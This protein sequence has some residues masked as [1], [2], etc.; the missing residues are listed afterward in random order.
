MPSD[1]GPAPAG[2][3]AEAGFRANNFDAIRLGLALL[4]IYSHAHALSRVGPRVDPIGRLTGGAIDGGILAVDG[5]FA[6]S[7]FLIA[8]SWSTSADAGRYLL[9]RVTR[10][11]P[12]FA[13]AMAVTAGV[14]APLGSDP[15][16]Y[17]FRPGTLAVTAGHTV[18]LTIYP[19][20]PA[21]FPRNPFPGF[22]NGSMWTIQYEFGCYLGL[23]AAAGLL[24]RRWAA[25][26]AL[27][28]LLALLAWATVRPPRALGAFDRLGHG[29][30]ALLFG[31]AQ[32][33]PRLAAHFWAGATFYACRRRIPHRAWLAAA[34]AI[35]VV[36]AGPALPVV[37]PVAGTYLL[38]WAA[39]HPRVRLH[40]FG[41]FGDF[42]YGT[43]LYAFPVQ[44]LLAARFPTIAPRTMFAA[45][46]PASVA[47]GVVSWYA[48]ERPW[49]RSRR[50]RRASAVAA[51]EP[52]AHPTA[53][54]AA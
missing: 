12:G 32:R 10:I 43:Y 52:H 16:T 42:S 53:G 7:G 19:Y 13:A 18:L 33:W 26:V 28:G 36:A 1:R 6:A 37:L 47:A 5:F 11:Y 27:V 23:A 20:A 21:A 24:A 22:A 38:L 4:V 2:W 54:G 45:A 25:V 39:Y 17:A 3:A 34:A 29:W 8:H 15:W 44:Q 50:N 41:R 51:L 14:V 9:K 40:R 35:A 48:V 30:L 31:S 46:A 49:L